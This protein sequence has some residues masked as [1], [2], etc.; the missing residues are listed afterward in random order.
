MEIKI[1]FTQMTTEELFVTMTGGN[2]SWPRSVCS[3][4][5]MNIKRNTVT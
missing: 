3:R 5:W 1:P 4:S 2:G